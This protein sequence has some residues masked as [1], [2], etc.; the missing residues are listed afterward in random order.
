[1]E[2]DGLIHSLSPFDNP[3]NDWV[4]LDYFLT[5]DTLLVIRHACPRFRHYNDRRSNVGI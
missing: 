2:S 5:L 3:Y 4:L 1:M